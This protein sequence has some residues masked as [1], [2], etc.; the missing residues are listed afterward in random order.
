MPVQR[1]VKP[2][3]SEALRAK[4]LATTPGQEGIILADVKAHVSN[5]ESIGSTSTDVQCL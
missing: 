5:C 1:P 3:D 4:I 2:A